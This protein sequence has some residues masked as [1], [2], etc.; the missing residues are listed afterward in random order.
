MPVR[1]QRRAATNERR[2]LPAGWAPLYPPAAGAAFSNSPWETAMDPKTTAVVL[3]EYPMF[4]RP[5]SH[6]EFLGQ[7]SGQDAT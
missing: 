5:L 4:S 2:R 3:I 6:T 7:L 1:A